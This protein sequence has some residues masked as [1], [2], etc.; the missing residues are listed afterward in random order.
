MRASSATSS[1]ILAE[2][3]EELQ[4]ANAKLEVDKTR[5]QLEVVRLD[6]CMVV[7]FEPAH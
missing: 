4:A 1:S 2:A 7:P 6:R 5:L 3:V